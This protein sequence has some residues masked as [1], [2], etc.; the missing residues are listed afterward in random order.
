MPVVVGFW[1]VRRL[2]Q[3]ASPWTDGQALVQT[4]AS[5]LGVHRPIDVLL[6]DARDGP[7]DLRS[8]EASDH[9]AG[10]RSTV[11]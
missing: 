1:Q 6:H 4:L 5:A 9:P 2:R 11:G 7:D 3:A 10:E 8:A